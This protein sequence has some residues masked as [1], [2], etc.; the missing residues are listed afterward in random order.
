MIAANTIGDTVRSI[1]HYLEQAGIDEAVSEARL[2]IGHALNLTRSE[3]IG[4]KDQKLSE[5]QLTRCR[6]LGKRRSSREPMAYLTGEKEFWG[7]PFKVSRETLI[8]RPDSETLIC[9][10]LEHTINNE[11]PRRLLDIGTGSGCLLAALLS[12]WAEATGVGIDSNEGAVSLAR[13]NLDTLGLADRGDIV[14]AAWPAYRS[15]TKFDLS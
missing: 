4:H 2:L 13:Q 11:T 9:A 12:E 5:I 10:V 6:S 3:V 14:A 7:L 8:P 15:D 1:A